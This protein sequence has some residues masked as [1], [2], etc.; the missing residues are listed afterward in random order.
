MDARSVERAETEL[1][2]LGLQ[3]LEGLLVA[4]GAFAVALLGIRLLP[5]VSVPLLAGGMGVAVLGMRA[6]VRRHLL[7]ED[8][9][10]DPDA[11]LIPQVRAVAARAASREHRLRLAAVIHQTLNQPLCET[12]SRIDANR[13]LLVE[14]EAALEDEARALDPAAAVALDRLLT[15]G[16]DNLNSRALPEDELR[17]RLH[18]ILD[19]FAASS[20]GARS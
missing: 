11:H 10:A 5:A 18:R 20:R 3:G 1:R 4:A 9:A 16:E 7:L 12:N 19:A 2:E 15:V 6:L 8:L 14:L 13:D 17:S